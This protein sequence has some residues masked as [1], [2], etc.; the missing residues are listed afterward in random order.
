MNTNTT[1]FHSR[2]EPILAQSTLLFFFINTLGYTLCPKNY[3]NLGM[4]PILPRLEQMQQYMSGF[5][6]RYL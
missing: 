2:N 5:W 1:F 6:A 4:K 3:L